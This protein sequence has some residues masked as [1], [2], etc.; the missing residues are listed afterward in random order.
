MR[1]TSCGVFPA[2]NDVALNSKRPILT[3][4]KA[5]NWTKGIVRLFVAATLLT[6][7]HQLAAAGEP[8]YP[9]YVAN[10][11]SGIDGIVKGT[12]QHTTLGRLFR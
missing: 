12:Q 8:Q 6:T 9:D 7:S 10:V 3:W 11:L 1:G 2:A 5:R 4:A